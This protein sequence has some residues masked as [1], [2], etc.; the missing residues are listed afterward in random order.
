MVNLMKTLEVAAVVAAMKRNSEAW[1]RATGTAEAAKREE[2][3]RANQALGSTLRTVYGVPAVYDPS[4]GVWYVG[5]VG[6]SKL[7]D[8]Y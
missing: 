8:L 5:S 4:T 2:L 6:G 7:Y 3:E 1:L